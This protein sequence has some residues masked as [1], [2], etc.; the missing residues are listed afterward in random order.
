MKEKLSLFLR[1]LPKSKTP[2]YLGKIPYYV[3]LGERPKMGNQR[4]I[5][6]GSQHKAL[7]KPLLHPR[8]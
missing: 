7:A 3:S 1:G 2:S 6:C 5:P 4:K 8:L